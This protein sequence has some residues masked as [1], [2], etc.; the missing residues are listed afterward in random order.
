[1]LPEDGLLYKFGVFGFAL[2]SLILVIVLLATDRYVV[3]KAANQTL[4]RVIKNI[5]D[6]ICWNI[7]I[8]TF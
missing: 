7:V 2:A 3:M 6:K 4:G 5:I 1:M 8:K